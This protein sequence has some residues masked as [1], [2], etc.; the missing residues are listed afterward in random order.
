MLHEGSVTC[1][2]GFDGV[3]TPSVW[4]KEKLLFEH[5]E[6]ISVFVLLDVL[7]VAGLGG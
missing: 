4:L 1:V 7:F 5:K 3:N 6:D 2:D